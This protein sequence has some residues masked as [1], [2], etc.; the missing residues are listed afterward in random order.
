MLHTSPYLRK[1]G[2]SG[3]ICLGDLPVQAR[4]WGA[5]WLLTPG[6]H[7]GL[8]SQPWKK[9]KKPHTIWGGIPTISL[10]GQVLSFSFPIMPNLPHNCDTQEC[11]VGSVI[12]NPGPP[13][14]RSLCFKLGIGLNGG[15]LLVT[16]FWLLSQ[17]SW[18]YTWYCPAVLPQHPGCHWASLAHARFTLCSP[19]ES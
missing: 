11:R 9:A 3:E 1:L 17:C 4:H 5:A 12:C 10:V 15:R 19:Y 6:G 18:K 14:A 13:W 2:E 7:M 16:A 8:L